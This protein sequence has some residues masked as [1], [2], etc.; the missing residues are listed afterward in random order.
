MPDAPFSSLMPAATTPPEDG[1]RILFFSGGTALNGIARQLKRYTHNSAH[2]ITPFDNGGSSQVLRAAFDMPAVGDLRSRL[3][4]LANEDTPHQRAIFY[5]FKHRLSA[6][7]TKTALRAELRS[8]VDASHPLMQDIQ[9]PIQSEVL[10]LLHDFL[11]IA[12]DD[13]DYRGASVGN[14]IL[15]GAYFRCGR[16]LAPAIE[17]MARL[18]DIQGRVRPLA[19]VNLHLGV[20]L[21]DGQLVFGQRHFT[22]KT[23]APIS[24]PI[25]RLFITNGTQEVLPASVALNAENQNLIANADVICFPPGSLYSSVIA[26]L[27]PAGVG[28]A[29]AQSDARKVYMP[30]LGHDPE[31]L[32]MTLG[33]QITALLAP[34]MSDTPDTLSARQ[35]ITDILCDLSVPQQDCD[36]VSER[37]GI[38][39]HRL[40]LASSNAERY[41][42]Q[43]VCQTLIGMTSDI[44]RNT[45]TAIPVA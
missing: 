45:A 20:A 30:N 21:A 37:F 1:A 26:N 25:R 40:P 13:F 29:V 42:P 16:Q 8:F 34:M 38:A 24:A 6:D 4:A 27:L 17:Q 35:F 5:L 43:T 12:P 14:L 36:A 7:A 10:G 44:A 33:D 31:A 18:V 22:G 28:R 2:L 9:G 41:D 23:T 32:G 39:C 11:H 3:M 19:D 15:T